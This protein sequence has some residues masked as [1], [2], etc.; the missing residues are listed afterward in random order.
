MGSIS[1]GWLGS[2]R[3]RCSV[4][5]GLAI[6]L[7]SGL[8]R[9]SHVWPFLGAVLVFLSGYLGLAAGFFPY[10]VPYGLFHSARPPIRTARLA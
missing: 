8:A 3:S 6:V 5:A 7:S 10:I 1:R 4:L 2:R 9:R